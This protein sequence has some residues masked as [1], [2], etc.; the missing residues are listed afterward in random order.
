MLHHQ[1]RAAASTTVTRIT[2]EAVKNRRKC[3]TDHSAEQKHREKD[4]V[5]SEFLLQ[6]KDLDNERI[7]PG[8][9]DGEIRRKND[10]EMVNTTAHKPTAIAEK[11]AGK[12]IPSIVH[13]ESSE[14]AY[15]E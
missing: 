6:S 10:E 12:R 1:T 11:G 13:V 3:Q 4:L 5:K 14:A 15:S 8:T 7:N 9:A 2:E